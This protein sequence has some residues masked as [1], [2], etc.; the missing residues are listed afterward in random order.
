[1]GEAARE[2]AGKLRMEGG[3]EARLGEGGG[4]DGDVISHLLTTDEH[5]WTRMRG[6]NGEMDF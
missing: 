6:M 1:M 3:E 4:G 2:P 5:G